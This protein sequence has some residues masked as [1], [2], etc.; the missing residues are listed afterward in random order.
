[1]NTIKMFE[2]F[3]NTSNE[4]NNDVTDK[5]HNIFLK[6][7]SKLKSFNF[8]T[9]NNSTNKWYYNYTKEDYEIFIDLKKGKKWSIDF[10][11]VN[12]DDKYF[13]TSKLN[14]NNLNYSELLKVIS[15]IDT[16]LNEKEDLH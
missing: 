14:K 12:N 2:Q 13:E 8:Q 6:K 10:D 9:E 7:I 4:K 11:L 1:M 15:K 3:N 16:I 5:Y